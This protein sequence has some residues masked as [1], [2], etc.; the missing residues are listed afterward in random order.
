MNTA[1][2]AETAIFGH[3]TPESARL[4]DDYPYGRRVRTQIRY[5]IETH[6]KHGDRFVSQTLKPGTSHWNAPKRSTYS[7]VMAMYVDPENGHVKHVGLGAWSDEGWITTFMAVAGEHLT[8]DQRGQV[9][10]LI[11]LNK[12]FA[13]VTFKVLSG[14]PTA[15]DTAAQADAERRIGRAVAMETGAALEQL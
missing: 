14:P 10:R 8:N 12:V 15:E 5:W 4:V 9:A 3:V 6:P 13:N 7:A 11:A 2:T 1:F